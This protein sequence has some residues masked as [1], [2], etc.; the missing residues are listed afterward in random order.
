M[1]EAQDGPPAGAVANPGVI[2][3]LWKSECAVI[4]PPLSCHGLGSTMPVGGSGPLVGIKCDMYYARGDEETRKQRHKVS[5]QS[6]YSIIWS[7]IFVE[8]VDVLQY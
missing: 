2:E 8:W 6:F 1:E 4:S 3:S 7:N 5:R